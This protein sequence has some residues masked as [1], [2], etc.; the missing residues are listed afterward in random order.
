MTD[1]SSNQ[2]HDDTKDLKLFCD[3]CEWA[4]QYWA[5]YYALFHAMPDRL[6]Q[7]NVSLREFLKTPEGACFNRLNKAIQD[8]C[9]LEIAKLHDKNTR[10]LTVHHI[11]KKQFWNTED[12]QE[13]NNLISELEKFYELL[14]NA[15]NKIL[16]HNDLATYRDNLVL[17]NFS[18]G[19]DEVYFENLAELCTIVWRKVPNKGAC[20]RSFTFTKSGPANNLLNSVTEGQALGEL[21][22]KAW[23]N[24]V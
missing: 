15:R 19:K 22:V 17:G 12:R 4:Y 16:A 13:I 10:S 7:H 1:A 20:Q 18:D 5:M 23:R 2:S 11:Q 8:Y 24:K 14:K 6:K 9:I 3:L 21:I